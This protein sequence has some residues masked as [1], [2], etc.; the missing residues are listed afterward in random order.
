MEE[1]EQTIV[2]EMGMFRTFLDRLKC[3]MS[4]K[5][6]LELSY[7][8]A[9]RRSELCTKVTPWE[10][11]H[12]TT[13]P[14]GV[15]LSWELQNYVKPDGQSIKL[16]LIKSAIAKQKK[17]QK[18]EEAAPQTLKV[19]TKIVPII[20]HPDYEPFCI[21]LLKWI[22]KKKKLQFNFTGQTASNIVK[23]NLRR[24]DPRIHH[25]SLRHYRINHLIRN[26]NFNPY[27]ISAYVGWSLKGVFGSM[28]MAASSNLD[29]YSHLSWQDYLPKLMVP[30]KS[31]L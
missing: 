16:L 28:G 5:V 13:K 31:V 30:I 22:A 10:S 24:L 29:I 23:R 19:K 20:C 7:L 4:E 1:K 3:P 25:H 15:M 11:E 21:D 6:F 8:L 9:A 27:Q 26:Y 17:K 14:Y 2:P 12:Q 18:D